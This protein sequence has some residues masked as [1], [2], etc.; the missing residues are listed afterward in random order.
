[1]KHKYTNISN[2]QRRSA[3]KTIAATTLLT[4]ASNPLIKLL[5][6]TIGKTLLQPSEAKAN[7]VKYP[8]G[9]ETCR[10][11]AI[12]DAY[13]II[14]TEN[15]YDKRIRI[16]EGIMRIDN[17]Y[18][19]EFGV[20]NYNTPYIEPAYWYLCAMTN[21]YSVKILDK[22]EKKIQFSMIFLV[23]FTII[24]KNLFII[25]IEYSIQKTIY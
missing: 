20:V 24:L 16:F 17:Q 23:V 4:A 21:D 8:P 5:N 10:D 14:N 7:D 22:L 9:I 3:L 19:I 18:S 2:P 12:K 6:A 13:Y 1:M 11:K 15:H 25:N